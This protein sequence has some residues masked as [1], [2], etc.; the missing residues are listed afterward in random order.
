MSSLTCAC[1]V[2]RPELN[3]KGDPMKLNFQGLEV[4]LPTDGAE[5]EDE[6]KGVICPVIM[7]T[8]RIMIF[9][10]P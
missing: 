5:R 8:P 3:V 6:K 4:N 10:M 2:Y 9:K 1:L 7:I